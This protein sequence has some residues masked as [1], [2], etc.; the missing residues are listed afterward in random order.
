MSYAFIYELINGNKL[1]QFLWIN[2]KVHILK[3]PNAASYY[4]VK[5]FTVYCCLLQW[6]L[7]GLRWGLAPVLDTRYRNKRGKT[8]AVYWSGLS[9]DI[10]SPGPP[11]REEQSCLFVRDLFLRVYS[12][13]WVKEGMQVYCLQ[14]ITRGITVWVVSSD[15]FRVSGGEPWELWAWLQEWVMPRLFFLQLTVVRCRGVGR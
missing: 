5:I 14:E 6:L 7:V 13:P 9:V 1:F 12:L 2:S 10:H 15:D 3:K 8:R 11:L 4:Q